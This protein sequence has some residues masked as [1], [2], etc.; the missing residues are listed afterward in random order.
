MLKVR[1]GDVFLIPLDEEK[2]GLG[3]VVARYGNTELFY[4]AAFDLVVTAAGEAPSLEAVK[5][6]KILFLANT[7]D[8]KL[9]YGKWNVIGN[10]EPVTDHVPFPSYK[11][12]EEGRMLVE[13]WDGKRRREA[14]E[15]EAELLDFRGGVAPI[16]LEKALKAHYG[17]LAWD[18]SFDEL[19]YQHVKER[20]NF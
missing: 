12:V 3:Q 13:S 7:F 8:A 1:V 2:S 14:T 16:R 5:G 20:S 6:L 18:P 19:R 15:N 11:I 4:M 9:V 17:I 10:V